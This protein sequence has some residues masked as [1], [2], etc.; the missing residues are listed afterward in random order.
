MGLSI[1]FL[2]YFSRSQFPSP[3]YSCYCGGDFLLL[4]LI[5]IGHPGRLAAIVDAD[6]G[7]TERPSM[8]TRP[9][10]GGKEVTPLNTK[11]T[12]SEDLYSWEWKKEF[13]L[14][15]IS[16]GSNFYLKI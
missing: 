15:I 2:Q 4:S 12:T 6:N 7:P 16:F 14:G 10:R 8:G 9:R 3:M 11:S 5:F 1:V 13:R